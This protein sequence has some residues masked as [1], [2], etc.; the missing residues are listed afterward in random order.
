MPERPIGE[1]PERLNGMV[2]KTIV[3]KSHREFESPS[4][5]HL[6]LGM[7]YCYSP[8][9]EIVGRKGDSKAEGRRARART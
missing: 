7:D 9:Q 4:L 3:A 6:S 8:Y 5:L 2:S 1:V